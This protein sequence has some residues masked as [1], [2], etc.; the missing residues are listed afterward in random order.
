VPALHPKLVADVALVADDQVLLVKYEDTSRYDGQRGWF[1]PDDYLADVEHPRDAASRIVR[2]QAGFEA[3]DLELADIESFG[4]GAWHL[5]F[6][7]QASLSEPTPPT[8]GANV[9]A[10]EWFPLDALPPAEEV[11]HHGW[12]LDTLAKI[13][14]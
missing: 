12:A 10:A 9:S 3:Q 1:L 2:E 7:F 4:N 14:A 11:A 6:H 8:H 5:I 13:R